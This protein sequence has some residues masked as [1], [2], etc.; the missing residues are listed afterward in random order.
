MIANGGCLSV[1][2]VW[3]DVCMDGWMDEGTAQDSTRDE[4]ETKLP[5][6]PH[7]GVFCTNPLTSIHISADDINTRK[8]TASPREDSSHTSPWNCPGGG[9]GSRETGESL[10]HEVISPTFSNTSLDPKPTHSSTEHIGRPMTPSPYPSLASH[11][12]IFPF[13]VKSAPSTISQ[14]RLMPHSS[15]PLCPTPLTRL[16][17]YLSRTL[18]FV[19]GDSELGNERGKPQ[20]LPTV[21]SCTKISISTDQAALLP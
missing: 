18:L 9:L 19:Y 20:C 17:L 4:E 7:R 12:Q 16:V 5:R 10:P 21:P 3:M 1:M 11:A 15:Q 2:Y 8:R 6:V 13:C 14:R